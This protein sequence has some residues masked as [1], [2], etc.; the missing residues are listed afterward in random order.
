[1]SARRGAEETTT[2][3]GRR[4]GRPDLDRVGFFDDVPNGPHGQY[5]RQGQ[6]RDDVGK[7]RQIYPGPARKL[8]EK[9]FRRIFVGEALPELGQPIPR[10]GR[11]K[12]KG[13]PKKGPPLLPPSPSKKHSTPGDSYGC[14]GRSSYFSPETRP[15]PKRKR[16]KGEPDKELPNFKIKPGKLGGPGVADICL[17]PFPSYSHDPYDPEEK[18]DK[19]KKKEA[20]DAKPKPSFVSTSA[21]ID[22]FP[23]NPYVEETPGPT[24]VRPKEVPPKIIGTGRLY[25]PFPKSLEIH[26]GTFGKFPPYCSDPYNPEIPRVATPGAP[27]VG[28]GPDLRMKYT[29]SIISQVTAISCNANNY[30]EYRERVYPLDG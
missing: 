27:W 16:K 6:I 12:D 17:N 14:F 15:E 7:G 29:N 20:R 4:Y 1:M 5:T 11:R 23:P 18:R 8:F 30:R 28:G 26:D 21:P 3:L 9:E 25:V 10:P 19:K 24:Y 2:Q 22:Y 13:E